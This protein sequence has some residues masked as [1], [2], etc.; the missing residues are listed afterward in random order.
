M[1]LNVVYH[2]PKQNWSYAYDH[3]TV[4]IR[5]RTK[6]D[7]M[8]K[9]TLAAADK[10]SFDETLNTI[11]MV[12][13]TSDE[14]F[15]YWE[16]SAKPPFRRL[17]YYFIL[18]S[19]SI[20]VY[21]TEKG[22]TEVKPEEPA[23][24][25][26]FPFI[27][28]IDVFSPP[29]WV[30]D[31]IFYQIFPD[32]F[33]NGDPSLNPEN[34]TP[35]GEEP[36]ST[37]VFGGDLQGII[38]H[39][40]HLVRLGVNAIYF[41]PLF[42]ANSSHKYDTRDYMRVDPHFGNND[43]LKE[44]V[45][46][47]HARGIR[48][49]LDAVF[50]QC[51]D[52]FEPFL[53]VKK[54][55]AESRFANWFHIREFP[56]EVKGRIPTYDTLAF[57]PTMPKLNTECSEVMEYL[58]GVARYWI[59]EIG[60][61]GWRLDVANEVD[62]A[63]WRDF[64]KVV[65]KANPEAYILGD[66]GN[67]AIMWLQGDQFDATMN[68]PVTGAIV[69]FF[70]RS[71]TDGKQ[72]ADAIGKQLGN[73]QR[74]VQEAA[75]NLLD[76]HDT[77]RLLTICGGD[78]NRMRLAAVFQFTFTGAPCIY[79]G[80]E[81][82]LDGGNEP[83]CRKCM[84]WD[85]NKQDQSLF[86][87]YQGLITLRK[88]Y[89]SLRTGHL[90]FR[91]AQPG[92]CGLAYERWDDDSRFYVLMNAQESARSITLPIPQG[93]WS[94]AIT[95]EQMD[96]SEEEST[97]HLPPFGYKI[98]KLSARKYAPMLEDLER[99]FNDSVEDVRSLQSGWAGEVL[100]VRLHNQQRRLVVKTYGSAENGINH[101]QRE[102]QALCFLQEAAYPV[103]EPI[104]R[105]SREPAPYIVMQEINGDTFWNRYMQTSGSK[106][107]ALL[108]QFVQLFHRLHTLDIEIAGEAV[109]E[110]STAFFLENE[111]DR[112]NRLLTEHGLTGFTSA[113]SWLQQERHKVINKALS[114]IHRDY[115]PWNVLIDMN[116]QC[117]V[118]D[119]LW[120]I[121]DFRYD[122]AWTYTLMER[123]G[124][125][126]FAEEVLAVYEEYNGAA[127]TNFEYFKV[128]ATLGWLLNIAVSLKTGSSVNEARKHEFEDFVLP[129]VDKGLAFVQ[130]VT[131]ITIY[132][133]PL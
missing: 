4:H 72:F 103:P 118:I 99:H 2:R 50:N 75:F 79:Y 12:K 112:M 123:G 64:R 100:S 1:Q 37:N 66:M 107:S 52:S 120:G 105:Q 24:L 104:M 78:K 88:Q 6:R 126:D 70:A 80:D 111:L 28:A 124:F 130:K 15:D 41:T 122:V 26:E 128:L 85:E 51:G 65:K 90:R 114:V 116:E 19:G 68:Y 11:P 127:V 102:W 56:L 31:A 129:L 87:F 132:I 29:P 92:D 83:E 106:R 125:A 44:L 115:H 86:A 22:F 98:F 63:F 74:Q 54:N 8:E 119:L 3:E 62:H 5:L 133:T 13:F 71:L 46:Q 38:D 43:K 82:G 117:F 53:D 14:F 91:Y 81:V 108:S 58:L 73:Y 84:V 17:Q 30:K 76:S 35:W 95:G 48:V 60:I 97:F 93:R 69:D 57:I 110:N 33:A 55:G 21:M 23:G 45:A 49:L 34:V 18:Q 32:R 47:C 20:T 94:D 9:V 61:D 27:H 25:F 36:T 16:A 59:D 89:A 131:G 42:E 40:D 67:D 7:D 10:Y 96:I 121:G 39:L 101:L 109:T 77:A 113:M